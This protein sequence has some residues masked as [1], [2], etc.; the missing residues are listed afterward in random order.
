MKLAIIEIK[1]L[2]CVAD[3][4]EKCSLFKS[5]RDNKKDHRTHREIAQEVFSPKR[6]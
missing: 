6:G 5:W 1:N 4:C 3:V 2:L